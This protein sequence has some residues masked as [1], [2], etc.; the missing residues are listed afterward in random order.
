MMRKLIALIVSLAICGSAVSQTFKHGTFIYT[1]VS[2]NGVA[3]AAADKSMSGNVAI[4][5]QVMYGDVNYSIT[6]IA[7]TGFA[8]CSGI[9]SIILPAKVSKIGW[10]AFMGCYNL[11]SVN[12]PYAVTE[13]P[14][15]AFCHCEMLPGVTL[16]DNIT[17]IGDYAF[18]HCNKIGRIIVPD[19][20]TKIGRKAFYN[21]AKMQALVISANVASI[22][23]RCLMGC[24][25]LVRVEVEPGNK[26]FRSEGSVLFSSD[27]RT[28][29]KYPS[30]KD[31]QTY[32]VPSGV[33][34]IEEFAFE[35]CTELAMVKFPPSVNTIRSMAFV[36]CESLLLANYPPSLREAGD[37]SFFGCSKLQE[38][39]M[40]GTVKFT[41]FDPEAVLVP[42]L[43]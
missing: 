16:P 42:E 11:N 4:P 24:T 22:G 5:Q 27:M 18:A 6:A 32:E 3:V 10:R 7:D 17:K 21:C 36:S 39:A 28:L 29:I 15:G 23:E 35:E 1:V 40:P 19:N 12:I 14:E 41:E 31:S 30:L 2:S 33:Q 13:I 34:K 25:G 9:K 26:F 43:E 38:S 8:N 20:C 37:D